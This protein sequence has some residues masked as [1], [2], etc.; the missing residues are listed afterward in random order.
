MH[1]VPGAVTEIF[2]GPMDVDMKLYC[3]GNSIPV[4]IS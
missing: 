4:N 3:L 2:V 1:V